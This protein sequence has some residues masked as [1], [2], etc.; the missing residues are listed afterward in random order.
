MVCVM[1]GDARRYEG[2]LTDP[3]LKELLKEVNAIPGEHWVIHERTYVT[4]KFL[5]PVS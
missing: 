5:G 4:K 1:W 2:T 3:H